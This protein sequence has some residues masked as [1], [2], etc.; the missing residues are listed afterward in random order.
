[1]LWLVRWWSVITNPYS[2]VNGISLGFLFLCHNHQVQPSETK[3]IRS[4]M[5]WGCQQCPP[6]NLLIRLTIKE[7]LDF[8]SASDKRIHTHTPHY[9]TALKQPAG[10]TS[11]KLFLQAWAPA[12]FFPGGANS[13]ASE[14][15]ICLVSTYATPISAVIFRSVEKSLTL[16][17]CLTLCMNSVLQKTKKQNPGGASAPPCTCLWPP[18]PAGWFRKAND[19]ALQCLLSVICS[20]EEKLQKHHGSLRYLD[21]TI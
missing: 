7:H 4:F 12:G 1:M 18:L 11:W 8:L 6:R 9:R 3:W 5:A 20:L 10:K 14:G 15:H 21:Q 17:L 13:E 2:L 19:S 16:S